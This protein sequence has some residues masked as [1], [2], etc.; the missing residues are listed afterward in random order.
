MT[1]Y[2]AGPEVEKVLTSDA[3]KRSSGRR[4]EGRRNERTRDRRQNTRLEL[5]TGTEMN[6]DRTWNCTLGVAMWCHP[7]GWSEQLA[8]TEHRGPGSF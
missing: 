7:Q 3:S 2:G 6:M 4:N 1:C 8:L 5:W